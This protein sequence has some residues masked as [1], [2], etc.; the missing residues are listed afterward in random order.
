MTEMTLAAAK[1]GYLPG[2]C[3][4]ARM[5]RADRFVLADDIQ[6]SKQ[7]WVNRTRISG[8]ADE[9]TLSVPVLTKGRGLQLIKDVRIDNTRH[10][11]KKHFR[12]LQVNYAYAPY[13]DWYAGMLEA[14]YRKKWEFLLDLNVAMIELFRWILQIDTPL[15]FAS[16][17]SH[18]SGATVSIVDITRG[19]GCQG[20]LAEMADK[21][22]L[23]LLLLQSEGIHLFTLH[24]PAVQS[25]PPGDPYPHP[26]S[27]FH[28]LFHRGH[29]EVREILE[30]AIVR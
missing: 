18:R 22:F 25:D 28:W 6:F 24:F 7:D 9:L 5:L 11:P 16:E 3:F 14:I 21:Q 15:H 29:E 13:F 20:Y 30:N 17:I 4:F 12:A 1:P 27:A 26:F 23:D 2:K 8:A 19:F 10:W